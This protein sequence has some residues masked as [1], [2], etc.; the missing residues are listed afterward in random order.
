VCPAPS[1]SS[2]QLDDLAKHRWR[3]LAAQAYPRAA[4]NPNLDDAVRSARRRRGRSGT[5]ST[6][7]IVLASTTAGTA[8]GNSSRRHLNSWLVFTSLHSNYGAGTGR[9]GF[10]AGRDF[11][12]WLGPTPRA[13]ERDVPGTAIASPH[14][15]RRR[16]PFA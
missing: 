2:Q 8:F 3:Y 1:R 10:P 13:D 4:A 5:I 9:Q 6:G 12:A 16:C 14:F 15:G 7:T 11:A